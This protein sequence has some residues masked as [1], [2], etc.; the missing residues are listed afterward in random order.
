MMIFPLY[1]AAI[2]TKVKHKIAEKACLLINNNDSIMVDASTTC[3]DVVE[4]L[5]NKDDLTWITNL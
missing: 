4:L 5:K 3:L 2:L 1:I